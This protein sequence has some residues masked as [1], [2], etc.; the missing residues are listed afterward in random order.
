MDLQGFLLVLST[1]IFPGASVAFPL[2]LEVIV[3][4]QSLS[5]V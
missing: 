5:R 1:W 3:V 2:A 4:V